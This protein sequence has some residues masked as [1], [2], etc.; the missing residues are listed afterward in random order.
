MRTDYKKGMLQISSALREYY[1]LP[2]EYEPDALV[3]NWLERGHFRCVIALLVDAM[4][5][6]ILDEHLRPDA[7]LNRFRAD[8]TLT[9]FPPTTSAATISF[10]SGR[11][12]AENGWLG[13]NQYFKELDDHVILFYGKS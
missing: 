8:D 3:K 2:Y 11:S 6:R 7:F 5:S 9:V 13:W 10:L 1:G 12:P 4:G